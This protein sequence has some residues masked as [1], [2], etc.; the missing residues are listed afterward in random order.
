MAILFSKCIVSS[1]LVQPG[2]GGDI[3]IYL[4]GGGGDGGQGHF[5][6]RQSDQMGFEDFS[7]PGWYNNV[8]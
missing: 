3:Y 8:S 7:S 5:F 2:G 6:G 4:G 1:D